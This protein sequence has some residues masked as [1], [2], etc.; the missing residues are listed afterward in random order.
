MLAKVEPRSRE[1]HKDESELVPTTSSYYYDIPSADLPPTNVWTHGVPPDVHSAE[2]LFTKASTLVLA[3]DDTNAREG[4][5]SHATSRDV[6]R[7]GELE[8]PAEELVRGASERHLDRPAEVLGEVSGIE[9]TLERI[10]VAMTTGVLAFIAAVVLAR[11]D[12]VRTGYILPLFIAGLTLI[13][14]SIGF[15]TS[16]RQLIASGTGTDERRP[17]QE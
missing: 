3:E 7:V 5:Q 17:I 14:S 8:G 11:Y 10:Q 15:L 1:R 16:V 6:A 12:V 13:I 9:Q 4:S 2:A